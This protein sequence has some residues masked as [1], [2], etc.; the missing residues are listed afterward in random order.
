MADFLLRVSPNVILGSHVLS[1]LGQIIP[2]WT[3]D[4]EKRFMLVSD[5]SLRDF[6]IEE[7]ALQSLKESGIEPVVFDEMPTAS[8]DVLAN[9]L[10]L[11]RGAR[12]RAVISLGG[13]KAATVGRALAALYSEEGDV[14]EYIEG[15]QP[16]SAPLPFIEI[17]TTCRDPAMFMNKTPIADAR[18]NQIIYMKTQDDVCKGVIIDPNVYI[19]IPENTQVA[20]LFQSAV[21][22][23]ESFVSTKS[24]FFSDAILAKALELIFA[25]LAAEENG[26]SSVAK[27]ELAAQG[28]L[29]ASLGAA[30]SAPG[31]ATALATACNARYRTP[32]SVVSAIL[33][34]HIV[35]DTFRASAEK[36]LVF[37]KVLNEATGLSVD[38][39]DDEGLAMSQELRSMLDK[40]GLPV[41][42]KDA[43]LAIEQLAAAAEDARKMEYMSYTPRAMTGD[44][45]FD[46][47][48][49]AY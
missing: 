25:A 4:A 18:N 48:K 31:A 38:G 2:R 33:L 21:L 16:A 44:D 13:I 5:P 34:P 1:R 29:L 19:H 14:Y 12:V 39:H 27:E 26:A 35:E 42:L 11:A 32:S 10:S 30:V 20:M 17:P 9:A 41:R 3:G 28:G 47:A 43:G 40:L 6:G 45:L 37:A 22:A 23:F 36:T 46:L 24:S 8:S 49:R 7:K 15:K